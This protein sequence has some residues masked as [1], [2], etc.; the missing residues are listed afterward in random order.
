MNKSH[1][2]PCE[3][4]QPHGLIISYEGLANPII[5][6][7]VLEN[8]DEL[9]RRG[10]RT[11]VWFL[12]G[13]TNLY[14]QSSERLTVLQPK[15]VTRIRLLRSVWHNLP[16]SEYFNASVVD[17]RIKTLGYSPQWIQARTGYVGA[18]CAVLKR[19]RRFKFI[20]DVR[21]D[22]LAE[23][24]LAARSRPWIDK[25]LLGIKL[26]LERRRLRLSHKKADAAIF[27][28]KDLRQ[29]H[30]KQGF[31][32]PSIVVPCVANP[33]LFYYDH[34]K[35]LETRKKLGYS[36][37][38]IVICYSGSTAVWQCA[39]ETI[40]LITRLMKCLPSVRALI[41]SRENERFKK[42]VED[43]LLNNFT[44]VSA[45]FDTVNEYLN[46]ADV[47]V[48]LRKADDVNRVASPVKFAEYSMAGLNVIITPSVAQVAEYGSLIGN[49]ILYQDELIDRLFVNEGE[50]REAVSR[51]AQRFYARE[52]YIKDF[53]LLYEK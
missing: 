26:N 9:N 6:S 19:K 45:E 43:S 42:L 34:T 24:S 40:E 21:G 8:A 50:R 36:A 13:T 20:L 3:G 29:L 7:Q 41:L 48:L 10:I 14:R 51:A 44:F 23:I 27:V 1:L 31:T 11:E 16:M 30:A 35:R 32:V 47:A 22:T 5:E 12:C 46:A 18:V 39:N 53:L 25:I 2:Q 15:H 4:L 37:N 49:T 38:D 28:S 17:A 33:A 52:N